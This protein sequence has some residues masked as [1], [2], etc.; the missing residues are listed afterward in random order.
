MVVI[1]KE[2]ESQRR[3]SPNK[4]HL[5]KPFV[6]LRLCLHLWSHQ[7]TLT[8]IDNTVYSFLLACC[9]LF[10]EYLAKLKI[11][12]FLMMRFRERMFVPL[13]PLTSQVGA[14]KTFGDTTEW[15]KLWIFTH[16]LL[17]SFGDTHTSWG[18][19]ENKT[20]IVK[21]V[22]NKLELQNFFKR[23]SFKNLIFGVL[24]EL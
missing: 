6:Y 5:E 17:I 21:N 22:R 20:E 16:F 7:I 3:D 23:F 24:N 2:H 19:C 13:F 4:V 10:I 14:K 1:P 18:H 11:L 9:P 8:A 12:D 15:R